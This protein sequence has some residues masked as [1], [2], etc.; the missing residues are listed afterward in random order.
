MK[1][2]KFFHVTILRFIFHCTFFLIAAF[3]VT[4][5]WA[6]IGQLRDITITPRNDS[7]GIGTTYIIEFTVD[8]TLERDDKILL[9]FPPEFDVSTAFVANNRSNLTGGFSV[10]NNPLTGVVGIQRDGHGVDLPED[11]TGSFRLAMIGNPIRPNTYNILIQTYRNG[12]TL[13]N[14]G[15]GTVTIKA[16]PLDHF[17]LTTIGNQIADN[18]FSFIITAK[19]IYNNDVA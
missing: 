2:D 6:Q 18:A 12:A 15:T 8:D 16:G 11:S 13:L 19:D 17:N 9:D 4:Q 10:D 3:G 1:L 14:Q 5:S 7:V